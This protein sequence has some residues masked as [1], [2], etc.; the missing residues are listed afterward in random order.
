MKE[1]PKQVIVVRRD[2]NMRKGKIAAQVAHA[3]LKAV[4]D[5]AYRSVSGPDTMAQPFAVSE[6]GFKVGTPIQEWLDNGCF[7][8]ICVYVDSEKDLDLI[9]ENAKLAGLPTALIVDNGRTE[10]NGVLTK[11]CVAVGPD[12]PSRIDPITGKLPLL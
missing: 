7:T 5:S 12:Y 10:F 8:K 3:S 4:L 11:T 1:E 2:L 6:Y 9:H